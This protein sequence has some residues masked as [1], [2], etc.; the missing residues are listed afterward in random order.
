MQYEIGTKRIN[1][2]GYVIVKTEDGS[3]AEHRYLMEQVIGRKLKRGEAV[4]HI[5][6]DKTDNR[7]ENLQLMTVS[8]HRRYHMLNMSD[9]ARAKLSESRRGR[10]I[11]DEHRI[12]IA[13]SNRRRIISD[14]TRAKLSKAARNLSDQTRAKMSASGKGRICTDET[15]AKLSKAVKEAWL[16]KSKDKH[17]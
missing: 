10:I 11:S 4:H 12:K 17:I 2:R 5:N 6:E 16:R 9:S 7:L 3:I 15:K 8:E 13:E 1:S 14:E